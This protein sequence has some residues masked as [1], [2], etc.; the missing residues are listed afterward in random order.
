MTRFLRALTAVLLLLPGF[1]NA[2]LYDNK[3]VEK[4]DV[5]FVNEPADSVYSLRM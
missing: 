1:T 5:I 4:I 2:T 3:V